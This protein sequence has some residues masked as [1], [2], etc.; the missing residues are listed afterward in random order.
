MRRPLPP[1]GIACVCVS[2]SQTQRFPPESALFA[3][4]DLFL[5]PKNGCFVNIGLRSRALESPVSSRFRRDSIR[6]PGGPRNS[7]PTPPDRHHHNPKFSLMP[8]HSNK[9][10]PCWAAHAPSKSL[11]APLQG[12][13][14]LGQF[15]TL[16]R[17]RSSARHPTLSWRGQAGQSVVGM[18]GRAAPKALEPPMRV[19]IGRHSVAAVRILRPGRDGPLRTSGGM[20]DT[21]TVAIPRH[22]GLRPEAAHDRCIRLSAAGLMCSG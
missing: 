18:A 22:R 3:Q 16:S 8:G 7:A 10:V 4:L 9:T 17:W 20:F 5:D 15:C 11:P 19:P 1:P 13:T 12:L 21:A 14:F 6:F 2:R